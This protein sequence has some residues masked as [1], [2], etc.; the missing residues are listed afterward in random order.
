MTLITLEKIA[1]FKE[2]F[3][4]TSAKADK[5]KD[6]SDWLPWAASRINELEKEQ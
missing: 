1:L 5:T 6:E 2:Q 4:S 3:V